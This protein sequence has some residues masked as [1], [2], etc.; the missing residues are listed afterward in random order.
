MEGELGHFAATDSS[1][2]AEER[3]WTAEAAVG[4]GCGLERWAR[5]V[6]R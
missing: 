5:E 2:D 4:W 3:R 1:K 6:D